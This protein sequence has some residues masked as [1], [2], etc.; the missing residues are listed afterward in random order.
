MPLSSNISSL[1]SRC[2][3]CSGLLTSTAARI[4]RSARPAGQGAG[5]VA[6]LGEGHPRRHRR[7]LADPAPQVGDAGGVDQQQLAVLP[8]AHQPLHL[9]S[10]LARRCPADCSSTTW[11]LM[12]PKPIDDTP[13]RIGPSAGHSSA[14]LGTRSAGRSPSSSGCGSRWP[15]AG[16]ITWWW[17][18]RIA[19]SSPP[20]PA[21][22][23][24]WPILPFRVLIAAGGA[25]GSACRRAA[26]N[27]RSSV[28]SP[29]AV[30]VP[31]PSM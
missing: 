14:V 15:V 16:G 25:S 5:Q 1:P 20:T 19:L 7:Q 10:D 26:E 18:A 12:P 28:A 6:E 21:A 17:M 27:A 4:G 29:T 22:A 2:S 11:V 24:V 9:R 3:A 13:A 23:L 31:C 8:G 30:P